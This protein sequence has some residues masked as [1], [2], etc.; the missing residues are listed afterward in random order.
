M[1]SP[2]V[3]RQT[4]VLIV[5]G[6]LVGITTGLLLKHLGVSF[7]LVEKSVRPSIYP[8]A[9]GFAPRTVEILRSI[10]LE[11]AVQAAAKTAF[12]PG[13][14]GGARRGLTLLGSESLLNAGAAIA[15]RVGKQDPSPCTFAALPQTLLEPVLLNA[16]VDRGGSYEAGKEVVAIQEIE[17]GLDVV[18]RDGEG[19]ETHVRASYLIAADGGRSFVRRHLGISTT[20]VQTDPPKPVIH[21][22]NLYFSADLEDAIAGKTFTQ[23]KIEGS[24]EGLFLAVNSKDRWSFH[25]EYDPTLESPADFPGDK[26]ISII[27]T[28]IGCDDQLEIQ[29][30]APPSL[31]NTTARVA[32]RYRQGRTFLVGD[33]AHTYPPYGGLGANTGIAD[34]H[35]L[36]W[37]IAASLSDPSSSTSIL[38]T[39]TTERR[40]VALRCA[41]QALLRSDFDARFG[42][43]TVANRSDVE[44]HQDL[45]ALLMRYQYDGNLVDSLTAQVGTRFP[46]TWIKLSATGQLISTL[47]LFAAKM[48]IVIAGPE[49]EEPFDRNS[50]T[51]LKTGIDFTVEGED[52]DDQTDK[53]SIWKTQQLIES[54][55]VTDGDKFLNRATALDAAF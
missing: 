29:M 52:M 14:F 1:S 40:P 27:R 19:E 51:T 9:G 2:A 12:K 28:A 6:G 24:V 5:G 39:Y 15:K 18:V 44:A 11:D 41:R 49:A 37:K 38:D 46:H 23:G 43:R 45:G 54:Q 21:F 8:R 36:C 3:P 32:E 10:G 55:E 4:S 34:A 22:A 33:A 53:N 42:V 48:E 31:W 20:I 50:G 17:N 7:I 25:Y 13:A 35:N 47:D 16:L 26:A 30:L